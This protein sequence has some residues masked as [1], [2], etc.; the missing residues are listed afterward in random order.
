M[1]PSLFCRQ[2]HFGQAYLESYKQMLITVAREMMNYNCKLNQA[3]FPH[4]WVSFTVILLCC[5][6]LIHNQWNRHWSLIH[7]VHFFSTY[8]WLWQGHIWNFFI[9]VEVSSVLFLWSWKY[10][11]PLFKG[12]PS[13]CFW[14]CNYYGPFRDKWKRLPL[15]R[16]P[17]LKS[18]IKRLKGAF[19]YSTLK[20]AVRGLFLKGIDSS[21]SIYA[22][23]YLDI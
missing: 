12:G 15:V 10:P 4:S 22:L 6:S 11:H 16:T 23:F 20:A 19:T 7:A 3:K 13:L 21:Q 14:Q 2:C 5:C 1:I 9:L 8:L 17:R 18:L